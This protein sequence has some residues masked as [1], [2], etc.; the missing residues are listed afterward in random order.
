MLLDR[1]WV[2]LM[3]ASLMCGMLTGQGKHVLPS[4]LEGTAGAISVTLKLASGY[5]FFCGLMNIVNNLKTLQILERKLRPLLNIMFGKQITPKTAEAVSMN[6]AANLLGLGNA[7]TP[8]GIAAARLL[9]NEGKRHALYML[10]I[11]NAT[12]IQLIPTTVLT[13][14]IAAGSIKPS[15]ILLPTLL[16]TAVSTFVGCTLGLLCRRSQDRRHAA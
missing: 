2:G 5:L 11:L 14:R 15:I 7:A 3:V 13:L 8:S 16:T 6:I 12:S 1:L 4:L 9:D 10:L